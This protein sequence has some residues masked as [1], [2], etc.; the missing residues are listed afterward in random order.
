[1]MPDNYAIVYETMDKQILLFPATGNKVVLFPS[2]NIMKEV[3]DK[4]GVPIP[5]NNIFL[6]NSHLIAEWER[7]VEVLLK[8]LSNLIQIDLNNKIEFDQLTE[9]S[10]AINKL[11]KGMTQDE[12][13]DTYH[14]TFGALLGK[15]IID[16]F[17]SA[18]WKLHKYYDV[19]PYYIPEIEL[20]EK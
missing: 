2:E 11:I 18:E 8:Q 20:E 17:K 3:I 4:I 7:N 15:I 16:N 19:N 5:S 1:Q 13:F 9:I 14:L 6:K 10:K 12:I